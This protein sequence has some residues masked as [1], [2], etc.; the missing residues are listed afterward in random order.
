MHCVKRNSQMKMRG[1]ISLRK[2][3]LNF[4][5]LFMFTFVFCACSYVEVMQATQLKEQLSG[6]ETIVQEILTEIQGRLEKSGFSLK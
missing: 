1:E 5:L 6:T 2:K 3:L 4:I